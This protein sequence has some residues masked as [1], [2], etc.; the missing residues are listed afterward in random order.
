MVRVVS[1]L[2]GG[3][4]TLLFLTHVKNRIHSGKSRIPSK[5][6]TAFVNRVR[7]GLDRTVVQGPKHNTKTRIA[8]Q[9]RILDAPNGGKKVGFPNRNFGGT[10]SKEYD[11]FLPEIVEYGHRD[12]SRRP[13]TFL[14]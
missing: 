10:S 8:S 12:G 7:A 5:V 13:K 2:V 14:V 11:E 6:A 9:L 4:S 1:K 3:D